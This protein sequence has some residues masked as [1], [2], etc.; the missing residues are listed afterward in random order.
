MDLRQHND[1]NFIWHILAKGPKGTTTP[2]DLTG[3]ELLVE[4]EINRRTVITIDNFEVD[5]NTL[6][7]VWYGKDQRVTGPFRIILTENPGAIGE[8]QIDEAGPFRL[9]A[10]NAEIRDR[11]CPPN[12]EVEAIELTSVVAVFDASS[13]PITVARKTWVNGVLESYYTK[14]EVDTAV[15]GKYAKPKG[16]IPK[17]DLS[18]DVQAS[19]DKADSAIQQHQDISGKQDVIADLETIRTGA[20][21]GAS[22]Y[23]KPATGVPSSD[24][25]ATVRTALTAAGTALQPA[26]IQELSGKVAALESLI[27]EDAEPTAAIDK[28]NEIVAF[29]STITNTQTLAGI[30]AGINKAVAAKYSKPSTGIPATDLAQAVQS[31]LAKA[32]TALQEHQ[33]ISHLATIAGIVSGAIIA[34]LAEDLASWNDEALMQDDM[35]ALPVFTTGGDI[36]IK[37]SVP[38]QLTEIA[39]KTDFSA[40]ALRASGFNLL[41]LKSNDGLAVAVG[42]GYY[43]PV[44]ALHFGT[45]NTAEQPNG[46]LFT[47][48]AGEN[49]RPTV[50][51]K[52]ASAGVPTSVTDGAPCSYVDA[53]WGGGTLRF[54]T[55]SEP[56]WLIVSGITWADTCAHIGWSKRYDGFVSPTDESDAGHSVDLSATIAAMHSFGKMLTVGSSADRIRRIS[57]EQVQWETECD[58]VQ[59]AWTNT[60]QEDGETY[61]HTAT[62]SAMKSDGA[63]Q[64]ETAAQALTI[65][66]TSISYTDSSESALTDYVKYEKATV[67]TGVR[68]LATDFNV[69]DWGLIVLLDAVG[70]AYTTIAYAQGIPDNVRALVSARLSGQMS[71]VAQAFAELYAE[72]SALLD[73]LSGSGGIHRIGIPV[74]D[75]QEYRRY[76]FIEEITGAGAPGANVVPVDWEKKHPGVKW[77]GIPLAPGMMYF[78]SA[79]NKWYKAKPVLTGAVADW[80]PLN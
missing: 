64:F 13:I 55:T 12:I 74:V 61:L 31:A 16:G 35:Q 4:I 62:I 78:D 49:L 26:D 6:S 2:Y 63:A 40:S 75:A 44:P 32:N 34:K 58:R 45:I 73:A 36:S 72:H 60:L 24:L 68:T 1:R 11:N 50:Y 38:A 71:V 3:K 51:F 67:A 30:V 17:T 46:V 20:A 21:A 48:S 7:F 66:G 80:V 25:A 23:Q 39:A 8:H 10:S 5:G 70:E 77:T 53:P 33:D 47:N 76:G 57:A 37:S 59:P 54:F 29:L 52:K 28:F 56:G 65:S 42:S 18:T 69:E 22:A 41:R 9:V 14:A 43:F 79:N 27:S 15:G 19:L